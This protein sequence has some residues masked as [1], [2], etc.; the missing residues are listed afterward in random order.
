MRRA[1]IWLAAAALL[2]AL[3]SAAWLE[4][5]HPGAQAMV[6]VGGDGNPCACTHRIEP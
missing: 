4:H 5:R 3:S 2:T 6:R 1:R